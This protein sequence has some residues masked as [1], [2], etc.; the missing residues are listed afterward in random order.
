VRS[1]LAVG[2]V[3]FGLGAGCGARWVDAV[4]LDDAGPGDAGRRLPMPD[5]IAAAPTLVWPNPASSANSD[6][7]MTQ[8]H[9]QIA[10]LQPKVLLLDFANRF[11]TEAGGVV[12]A[13]YDLASTLQPLVQQH[14]E[15]LMVASQY[16]G[17]KDPAAPAFLQYQIAKIVDLRDGSASV[18]SALVP[19]T[20]SPAPA[21]DY[22]QLNNATF[23]RL[24]GYPDPKRPGAYL[25]L[26]SLFE[27]GVINE[28]WAMTADPVSPAD[29]PSVKFAPIAETKQAY[30]PANGQLAGQL[31]CTSPT[32]IDKALPCGVSVRI[33]DFNPGRG[34][35]CHLFDVGL[36]WQSY[37]SAGVLPAFATA[38]KTFF[39]FDFDTRFGAPFQSFYDVCDPASPPDAG[40]CIAWRSSTE[41]ASGPAAS[42]AFDFS[43]MSAGCGNVV[44]PP[45]ATGYSVQGG[46]VT[47][48]TSC[49]N[50]GLHNGAG[51]LDVTTPYSNAM[52]LADYGTNRAV[53]SDCG[54]AQPSYLLASMP[55]LGTTAALSDG[56]PMKNWWVYLFY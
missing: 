45:N 19:L 5:A 27:Q 18:N 44:F 46:D 38:A 12:A 14:V 21:V 47:V 33:L 56:T 36:V 55:G 54:G 3:A 28:V 53:A 23:A 24:M 49:E 50:Y 11:A 15:A 32:C 20:T 4:V 1:W 52:A 22:A 30:D 43:P 26:C 10:E 31:L 39:N 35:G 29:P 6:P 37:L 2:L 25:D 51:G 16:H 13:G 41:A 9:D 7:W 17:Y 40:P 48:L 8:H 34:A 42:K